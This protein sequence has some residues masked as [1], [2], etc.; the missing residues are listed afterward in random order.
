MGKILLDVSVS[1]GDELGQGAWPWGVG[2]GTAGKGSP[3][4]PAAGER[5]AGQNTTHAP[6]APQGIQAPNFPRTRDTGA[7]F[8]RPSCPQPAVT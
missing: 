2:G 4:G 7:V 5:L 6:E 8:G 1:C 3:R